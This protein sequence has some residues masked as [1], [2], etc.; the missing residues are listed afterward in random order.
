MRWKLRAASPTIPVFWDHPEG[1]VV[2]GPAALAGHRHRHH[3]TAWWRPMP[4]GNSWTLRPEGPAA[5]SGPWKSLHRRPGQP[6]RQRPASC[7][8]WAMTS[9]PRWTPS[10]AF[11]ELLEAHRREGTRCWITPRRYARPAHFCSRSST[12]CWKW[13]ASRAARLCWKKKPATC[14]RWCRRSQTYLS[15]LSSRKSWPAP[16][17]R[18]STHIPPLLYHGNV[19]FKRMMR[20]INHCWRKSHINI[21]LNFFNIF[22]MIQMQRKRN[23]IFSLPQP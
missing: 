6:T 5:R 18:M 4:A 20:C 16:T 7:S 13:P 15:P 11:S 17:I 3:H 2:L 23:F 9:A 22:K 1:R 12:M 10:S 19:F 8:I 21:L 14:A